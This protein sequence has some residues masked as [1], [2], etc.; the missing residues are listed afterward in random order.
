MGHFK[1]IT[2]REYLNKITNKTFI[3]STF[4]TPLIIVGLIF[5]IGYLS[6]L[7]NETVKN[8]SVIDETGIVYEKLKSS[9]FLKYDLI[10]N[11]SLEKARIFSKNKSDYGLVY[12]PN[13]TSPNSI[14]DSISFIS[15]DSP[16]FTII[17]NLESQLEKILTNENFKIEG[18]DIN[19]INESKVYVN[20]FQET[21]EGEKT[22]KTDGLVK[23]IFGMVL[24]MLLYIF[25]FAYGSMIMM[26][27]I[28]EKTNRIIE[29]VISSV[30]PFELMTGKIIGTSLAGLT[31]F[32][33][34]G[35]L[36]F[37]FSTIISSLFGITSMPGNPSDA[38]LMLSAS[39]GSGI[40]SDSLEIISAFINL[41]LTNILVAFVLYF[42]GGYLLYASIF[43][44]IGAAVDNQTDAQQFLMP[45]TIILIVALYV[46]ILTV[47]ED[48]NGI[49]AQILSFI[50][51]TS[52]VVMMMRIPYGV[53]VFE[54]IISVLILFL[55]V[56]LIIW[57]AAKIYRIGILMY[58]KK[59]TYR[60]LL[61]WL[62]Y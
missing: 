11:L 8:I 12:I 40:S 38:Q 27:V 48:P 57:I 61:K 53:P 33:V 32:V 45:I 7:N 28:E 29:I 22:T 47:P 10:Q 15:E 23:L 59:P 31:Q 14:A 18:L 34:W 20:L 9:K 46:G 56:I 19:E 30:K 35:V 43:A 3:L 54:Q 52:P 49:V 51:L 25:I 39:E 62:K 55:S 6:N 17:N 13:L 26:S 42:L 37:V 16:S 1:L 60:E 21:F 44:A 4:L 58:G 2:T 5:F 50:P 41:P 24:G 36:F